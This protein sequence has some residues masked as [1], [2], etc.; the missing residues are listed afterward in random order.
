MKCKTIPSPHRP[1][2]GKFPSLK[3]AR[4]VWCASAL[5][6][7][8][9]YVLELDPYVTSYESQSYRKEK[10]DEIQDNTQSP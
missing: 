9:L 6:L 8:M 3:N 2:R 5:E 1:N 10:D 4:S 7:N